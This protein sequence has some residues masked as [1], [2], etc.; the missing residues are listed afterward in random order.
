MN[1]IVALTKSKGHYEGVYNALNLIE[2]QIKRGIEDKRR[3]LVKP[4]FVSTTRQLSATHVDAVKAI[5]DIVLKYYSGNIVIGEGPATSN[6]KNGLTN[7]GYME[8]QD[9]YDVD[10][11]DLN[12]DSGYEVEGF[13]RRL[14]PLKY[15]LSK[16]VVESDYRISVALPKTHDNVI[17][18]LSIK[19]IVV[20]SLIDHEKSKVHQGCKGIN[21]NLAKFA[22]VVM[23]HLGVI[24][25]FVGMEGRGPV[26]GDPVDFK[27]AAASLNPVSLDSVISKAM[28]F[29]PNDIG[30]LY[31]LSEWNKGVIDLNKIEIIGTSID[32]IAKNFK[33]HPRYKDMLSWKE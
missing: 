4:N 8:L 6:L 17:T 5:L 25:G 19:N 20:G 27:V 13:D 15:C 31:H 14:N 26:S 28:G 32:K 23:P 12:K 33:P 16:T 11:L 29:N 22:L 9:E 3:V 21:L 24:D 18:T 30:Y 2:D 7:Y 1:S 10:F